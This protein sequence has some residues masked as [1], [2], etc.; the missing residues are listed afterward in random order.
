MDLNSA[1]GAGSGDSDPASFQV[2]P[3]MDRTVWFE[4]NSLCILGNSTEPI[5]MSSHRPHPLLLL[6]PQLRSPVD[7]LQAI[8]ECSVHQSSSSASCSLQIKVLSPFRSLMF[9]TSSDDS[10][11][12]E[13]KMCVKM[14]LKRSYVKYRQVHFL[15]NFRCSKKVWLETSTFFFSPSPCSRSGNCARISLRYFWCISG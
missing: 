5:W 2:Y 10:I 9:F 6:L 15:A 11:T 13:K 7:V 12:R 1:L 3:S 8:F 14:I 4:G